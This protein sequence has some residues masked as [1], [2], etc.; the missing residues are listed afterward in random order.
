MR[1]NLAHILILQRNKVSGYIIGKQSANKK[2]ITG[3]H[4]ILVGVND[5]NEGKTLT[6]NVVRG[7][8]E[9]ALRRE[10]GVPS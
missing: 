4:L 3:A 1:V 2:T 6:L 9:R 7:L 10:K 8:A 5:A